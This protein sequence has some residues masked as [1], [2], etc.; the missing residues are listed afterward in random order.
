M[1]SEMCIRDRV[2]AAAGIGDTK[3]RAGIGRRCFHDSR[4]FKIAEH[5]RLTRLGSGNTR[6][7]VQPQSLGRQSQ[8]FL[9][10]IV[11]PCLIEVPQELVKRV[12]KLL[13]FIDTGDAEGGGKAFNAGR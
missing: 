5:K 2:I 9:F 4:D 6:R 11:E 1:G 13:G 12:G 10:D 8:C 7:R 3:Q